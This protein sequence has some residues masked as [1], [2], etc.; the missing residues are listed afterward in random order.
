MNTK[1]YITR[2]MLCVFLLHSVGA[3]LNAQQTRVIFKMI[4]IVSDN[5]GTPIA[6]ATIVSFYGKD[7][8]TTDISGH[9]TLT[10][11]DGST[12]AIVSKTGY[13]S[14][15]I[16]SSLENDHNV[17]LQS[18]AG[19]N[20]DETFYLG[21]S[22]QRRGELSG[23]VATVRGE[24]L[25]RSPVPVLSQALA[26]RLSGLYTKEG[27]SEP[28]RATTN[29]YIRGANSVWNNSPLV[30]IDGIPYNYNPN[31]LMESITASEVESITLLK[32]A[33]TQALYG[34]QGADGVL[35]ITTKRGHQGK[36]KVNIKV[37]QSVEQTSTRLP[38]INSAEY[39]QLRNEAGK[40]DGKGD[41][42]YFSANDVQGF[43]AGED[44]DLYPNNNWRKMNMKDMTDQQRVNIDLQGGGERAQIYTNFNV[45]HQGGFWKTDQTKYDS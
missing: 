2:M 16:T 34:I 6:D 31:Q 8:T 20:L 4:G 15:T 37:D 17:T 27:Y 43:V 26:G 18:E 42:A 45:M 13:R 39:V 7:K 25:E 32:D 9:Y 29:L 24:E 38:F 44:R 21:Y 40:N 23:A 10:I 11:D 28:A 5:D 3:G 12:Q 30:V 1:I 19:Y 22:T 35:V 33:S 36:L 41:Y 14:Q